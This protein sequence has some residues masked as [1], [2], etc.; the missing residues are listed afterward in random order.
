MSKPTYKLSTSLINKYLYYKSNPYDNIYQQ[1]K[2]ALNNI[3][4]GNKFTNRGEVYED[5]VF[6]GLHG[7]LSKLVK[8]LD[9][10]IWGNKYLELD[11]TYTLRLAG[12]VDAI[13]RVKKRIYD[14]KRVTTFKEQNF[15]DKLTVQHLVYF[16][17]FPEVEAFY[18][19]V[20]DDNLKTHIV[21]IK[22]SNY[23]SIEKSL[24]EVIN[25]FL[26]FLKE[27]GLLDMYKE[28]YKY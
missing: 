18:Y 12:K 4:T 5:E 11:K 1:L 24:L 17:L 16:Y 10:Q 27:K 7:D 21:H 8:D 3:W 14:I 13:D 28:N 6:K 26:L 9:K 20:T 25:S 15:T 23:E 19:L 22:R 2:D